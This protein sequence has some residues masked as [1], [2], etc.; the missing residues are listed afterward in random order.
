MGPG[1]MPCTPIQNWG[2]PS[3]PSIAQPSPS[4]TVWM[5]SGAVARLK[6]GALLFKPHPARPLWPRIAPFPPSRDSAVM[7]RLFPPLMLLALYWG[8]AQA[9]PGAPLVRYEPSPEPVV[10]AMTELAAV[11]P[12]DVVYDLGCGDGRIVVTAVRGL[13]GERGVGVAP[14]PQGVK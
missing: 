2:R 10:E 6:R 14:D 11:K 1:G 12:G 5:P 4:S 7:P 3:L 9:Q 8:L 13:K